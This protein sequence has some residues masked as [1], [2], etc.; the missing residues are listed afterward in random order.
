MK[1]LAIF[2][3]TVGFV[4]LA[5]AALKP[6]DKLS[7]YEIK[8]VETGKKYCQ[9]CAYSAKPGKVV[10][11]GKLEDAQFWAD[12]K[13]LQ[14]LQAAYPKLGIFAQVIDSKNE[15]AIR[16]AAEKHG[17]KFPVVIAV[18]K[19]WNKA[20]KVDGV[21]RTIYYAQR[22][23]TIAWTTVGLDEKATEALQFQVKKDFAG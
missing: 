4:T 2:I 15:K 6:G 11:F 9:V 23:N 3:A 17:I 19:N 21:S 18:E 5:N 13:K 1:K 20:Y 16:A 12:L 14:D 22:D 10:A 8:N 7:A